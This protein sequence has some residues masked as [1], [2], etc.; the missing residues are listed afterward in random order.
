[1][2]FLRWQVKIL[3]VRTSTGRT[4]AT[5][6]YPVF[7]ND[8]V[9]WSLYM[10]YIFVLQEKGWWL[11]L[12]Y[13]SFEQFL[14]SGSRL[15]TQSQLNLHFADQMDLLLAYYLREDQ[16]FLVWNSWMRVIFVFLEVNIVGFFLGHFSR[17]FRPKRLTVIQTFIHWWWW[18]SCKVPTSTSGALGVQYPAQ[19]HF[20]TQTNG[21]KP[22]TFQWQ[23]A[24][25]PEPKL[26]L[27]IHIQT[28]T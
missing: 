6:L 13:S 3:A 24:K 11:F 18:L 8:N 25:A 15:Y 12:L 21:I 27:D 9:F 2:L 7:F 22:A 19:G 20:N 4:T 28:T 16:S 1:M 5:I 23:D 17:R 26:P 10:K 14:L